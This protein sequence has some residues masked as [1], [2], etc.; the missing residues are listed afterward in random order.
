VV[1]HNAEADTAGRQ[2]SPAGRLIVLSGPAGAGKTT[3]AERLCRETGI[4]RSVSATTRPPR[5][6]EVDGRDYL[7]LTEEEFQRRIAA[8]GFLEHARVHGAQYGT[9]RAPIEEALRE[10]QS[11]LLVIDV[12]GAMQVKQAW[13]DALL[14]FLDA[15][16]AVLDLRLA[17]RA[18]ED[19]QHRQR[20]L[21]AAAAERHYKEQYDHC[22]VNDGL[23][24]AVAELRTI[25]TRG[26]EPEDRRHTLDG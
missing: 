11:R 15:P 21:A 23:D 25:L 16:D 7:F 2:P 12:Q 6:G 8:G 18:T 14:L 24:Q 3:V 13:P 19:G 22:V 9:P 10:G 17:G 26:R 4:R 5:P 1:Q 20:R